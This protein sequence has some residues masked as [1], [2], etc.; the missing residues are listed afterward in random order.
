MKNKSES[1]D[2]NVRFPSRFKRGLGIALPAI[3]VVS[4]AAFGYLFNSDAPTREAAKTES[5]DYPSNLRS[6]VPGVRVRT[7]SASELESAQT[8]VAQRAAGGS[9]I[10]L[11]EN[12]K[13]SAP[14]PGFEFP[15]PPIPKRAK[16]GMPYQSVPLPGGGVLIKPS[17]PIRAF[18]IATVG[19]D[20]KV[21]VDCVEDPSA[22][23]PKRGGRGTGPNEVE[24]NA[25]G[26]EPSG[27]E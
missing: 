24:S 21:K 11:D 2:G 4:A 16:A 12:G 1:A 19:E 6:N 26:K 25:D 22:L 14:P 3:L 18:S 23:L 17:V 10:F 20:G 9:M 15:T 27:D 13:P 5:A 8:T 7:P